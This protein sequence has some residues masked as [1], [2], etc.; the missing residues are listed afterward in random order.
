MAHAATKLSEQPLRF[1]PSARPHAQPTSSF[2]AVRYSSR[3]RTTTAQIAKESATEL[4]AEA[5][6]SSRLLGL[7]DNQS[8]L[9]DG[10]IITKRLEIA[11]QRSSPEQAGYVPTV[12]TALRLVGQTSARKMS[13]RYHHHQPRR[14]TAPLEKRPIMSSNRTPS[15]VV[16]QTRRRKPAVSGSADTSAPSGRSNGRPTKQAPE[17]AAR[18]LEQLWKALGTM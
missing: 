17:T 14:L 3:S 5:L 8:I 18:A 2:S 10:L 9:A 11:E 7:D 4:D 15:E 16:N 12:S 13:R 6:L 1:S